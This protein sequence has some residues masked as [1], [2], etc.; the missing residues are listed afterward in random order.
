MPKLKDFT[1]SKARPLPVIVLA[2]TS[3]SMAADGK[4]DALNLA[5]KEMIDAFSEQ[6][7]AQAELH[8][9][10]I[11]FGQEAKLHQPLTPATEMSW[12]SLSPTGRTPMGAAF[13]LAR[14]MIEDRKQL[15]SRAYRPTLVL[16]SDGIPTDE[17]EAALQALQ[18]S[19]RAGKAERFAMGIGEEAD[20]EMLSQ[21]LSEPDG[22]VFEAHEARQIQQF[23]R[24]VTMSV[25]QR[26][27][28]TTP[29]QSVY[30]S[31]EEV[32]EFDDF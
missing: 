2:D 15:P 20:R 18:S 3:G 22:Q 19:E 28:S 31:P 29:N 12:S 30:I 1:I 27:H 6:D 24:W 7:S 5:V 16:V 21:F 17:W 26:L 32:D 14:E 11:T 9:A 13:E 25:S 8:L 4:I 23:F 10:I